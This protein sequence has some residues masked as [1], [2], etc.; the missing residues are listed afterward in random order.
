MILSQQRP[1]KAELLWRKAGGNSVFES[2]SLGH[3]ARS[4][5]EVKLDPKQIDGDFEYYLRI[6]QG[7]QTY[8][9]PPSAPEIASVV[10]VTE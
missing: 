3:I 2:V 7:D 6:E 8:Y 5:Y 9:Y 4:V 10:I 1:N